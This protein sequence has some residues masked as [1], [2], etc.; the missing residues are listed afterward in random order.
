MIKVSKEP[1]IIKNDSFK[2]IMLNLIFPCSHKWKDST[3]VYS[4]LLIRLLLEKTECFSSKEAFLNAQIQHYVL[5]MKLSKYNMGKN[6]CISMSITIPDAQI[7][8]DKDYS[9]QKT[10][11]FIFDS[12]YHPYKIDNAF[13]MDDVEKAKNR[14]KHYINNSFKDIMSYSS[15]RMD[16]I[17][18]DEGLFNDTLFKHKNEIDKIDEKSLY[19]FY[20]ETI[21]KNYPFIFVLGNVDSTFG[22]II[23]NELP[24]SL[25]SNSIRTDYVHSFS[26]KRIENYIEES[27]DYSQSIVKFAYKIEN[28]TQEDIFMLSLLYFILNS[29]SSQVLFEYLRTKENLVYT[30][31]ASCYFDYG[32]LFITAQI[33][34]DKKEKTIKTIKE[35][36]QKLEDENFIKERLEKIKERKRINL[37]RQK[38]TMSTIMGDF[39][40]DY[41]RYRDSLAFE[42]EKIK[43]V[44]EKDIVAFVKRLHLD[45]IY[46]LEGTHDGK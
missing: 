26:I 13:S 5:S 6:H 15:I 4:S 36:M 32:V 44:T 17:I 37:E 22:D 2:K 40:D 31:M 45:T 41:F 33:Y 8:Q 9:Y 21:Q 35:V 28:Y 19:Q 46:Y 10:I 16:E 18:D 29:Q 20:Q 43:V 14:L 25:S 3:V 42:Y 12:L 7:L 11:R 1:V 24:Q 38:D 30:A 23:K 34:R 27:K 39:I